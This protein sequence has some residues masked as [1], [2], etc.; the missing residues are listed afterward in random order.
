LLE[1]NGDDLVP[2]APRKLQVVRTKIKKSGKDKKKHRSNGT[3]V[4]MLNAIVGSSPNLGVFTS[5]PGSE[6]DVDPMELDVPL[7]VEDPE[8]DDY[9]EKAALVED[10]EAEATKR[11]I[12]LRR[13]RET[14]GTR[15]DASG[16]L[17]G[18]FKIGRSAQG[19]VSR[20]ASPFGSP[21]RSM[22]RKRESNSE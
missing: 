17:A 18:S 2:V 12:L 6:S 8:D 21:S 15:S 4:G 7:P 9:V 3:E 20:A 1:K 10:D 5:E 16:S 14:W 22:K 11:K 19:S 13:K